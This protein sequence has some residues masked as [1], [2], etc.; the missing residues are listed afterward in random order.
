MIRALT[1]IPVEYS[2]VTDAS[3]RLEAELKDRDCL[4]VLDDVWDLAAIKPFLGSTATTARLITTRDETI[5]AEAAEQII[6][7]EMLPAE[8]LQ[9]LINRLPDEYQPA[10]DDTESREAL[11]QLAHRLGEWPLL[12]GI[13]G[14]ELRVEV[15]RT[16]ALAEALAYVNEGLDEEGLTAF[17]RD[18]ESDRNAAL[19]ASMNASLRRFSHD[20]RRRLYE[21]AIFREE[22]AVPETVAL[23]LWAATVGM[24]GFKAKKLLRRLAGQ[25]FMLRA[26]VAGGPE[27]LRFHD[28]MRQYLKTQ[29][30]DEWP[31][32][33]TTFLA[34]FNPDGLDWPEVDNDADG[35]LY[36]HLAY[37]L[38]EAGRENELHE[39]LTADDR[40]LNAQ[41]E[42][43]TSITAYVDDLNLAIETYR[44]PLTSDETIRLATLWAARSV[45]HGRV[46]SYNDTDLTT[47]VWLGREDEALGYARLRT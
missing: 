34:S 19:E 47:L 32:L 25:F 35:Y 45:I 23:R 28:T 39:L 18:S 17:D 33:H 41:L 31:R 21:L 43:T 36:A 30:G 42:A 38:L 4:L 20:E 46:M 44:D 2:D 7:S 5:A 12:L 37:H 40:W 9:L 24:K 15:L 22:A 6:T 27:L 3:R 11:T 29:L 26:E 14:G 13:I 16:K 8:A 1:G 10:D